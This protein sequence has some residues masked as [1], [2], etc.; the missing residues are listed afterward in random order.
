MDEIQDYYVLFGVSD[1]ASM[2][3]IKRAYTR[4]RREYQNDE[5]KSTQLNQAYEVLCDSAKRKQYDLNMQ[6]GNQVKD[7]KEKIQ[8]SETLEQRDKYL[9]EARKIYLDILKK[10]AENADALWNLVRIEELLGNDAEAIQYLKKLE[11]CVDGDD[12]LS[13]YQRQGE[14]YRKIGNIDEAIKS[15]YAI[16]KADEAYTEAIKTL[17]RLCY[18]DKKNIKA[19]IQILNDCINRSN[20]SKVKIVYLYETMR[21]VRLLNNSSYQK[22]EAVLYKKLQSFITEDRESNQANAAVILS[23]FSDILDREDFECFHRME[24]IY[25][26]FSVNDIE[27]NR[28]FK[29]A[30]E[31]ANLMEKG[32]VHKAI[33]LYLEEQWTKETREQIGR[34]VIKEAEQIKASLEIIKKEAPEYWKKVETELVDLEKL[35]NCKTDISKEYNSLLNDRTISASM[36]KMLEYILIENFV[37]FDDIRDEFVRARDY[38]FE[39]EDREKFRYTLKKMKEYYP[40]CYGIFSDIFFDSESQDEPLEEKNETVTGSQRR[41]PNFP[42]AAEGYEHKPYI[43][44]ILEL[45]ALIVV[46]FC[47]PPAIPLIFIYKYIVRHEK[48]VKNV[49]RFVKPIIIIICA[50]VVIGGLYKAGLGIKDIISMNNEQKYEENHNIILSDEELDK[51]DKLNDKYAGKTDI[52]I[53]V[54]QIKYN[55]NLEYP[56]QSYVWLVLSIDGY[57]NSYDLYSNCLTDD[58]FNTLFGKLQELYDSDDTDYEVCEKFYKEAYSITKGSKTSTEYGESNNTEYLTYTLDMN[59][60]WYELYNNASVDDVIKYIKEDSQD[61][62]DY[63]IETY[64]KSQSLIVN[65]KNGNYVGKLTY[66]DYFDEKGINIFEWKVDDSFTID[67]VKNMFNVSLVDGNYSDCDA[68]FLW[69]NK[70]YIKV[71][72]NGDGTYFEFCLN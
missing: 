9:I 13:V 54:K 8:N 42:N 55:S 57:N 14:I 6:Y 72:F 45:I 37:D 43:S 15:Y 62:K 60:L 40:I 17:A 26:S 18:E 22:V 1:N 46:F 65:G 20:D 12:K 36:K 24:G 28:V 68:K 16:Y 38:F 64:N 61:K 63:G 29:A 50:I 19:A 2:E 59:M 58:E 35:V 51:R 27:L 11:K 21:A 30:Q 23:C 39:K 70:M 53:Q 67:D 7:I 48:S 4:K 31:M 3:E 32:K 44:G 47:F 5:D 49:W 25:Q 56:N 66:T 41:L 52:D 34:L 69:R 71:F 10:D 33:D